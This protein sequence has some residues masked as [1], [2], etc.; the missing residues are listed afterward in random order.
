MEP[1][2]ITIHEQPD[3]QIV[4][5]FRLE[6]TERRLFPTLLGLALVASRVREVIGFDC[7]VQ[8]TTDLIGEGG[9]A[10]PPAPAVASPDM[11][12]QLSG[13]AARGTR[14]AQGFVAYPPVGVNFSNTCTEWPG[15]SF[16]QRL[17]FQHFADRAGI[18]P[19]AMPGDTRRSMCASWR[20]TSMSIL[21]PYPQ[22]IQRG[23]VS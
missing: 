23:A 11:A 8:L 4:H 6:K 14:E 5:A 17:R 10:Q 2:L 15:R 7:P 9:M 22:H 20:R 13:N 3:S 21:R 1:K 16:P 18:G 19:C 12:P